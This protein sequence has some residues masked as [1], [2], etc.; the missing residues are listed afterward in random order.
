MGWGFGGYL[1]LIG[2]QHN[3]DLFRCA[4]GINAVTYLN[5]Q[6]GVHPI[7]E[8]IGDAVADPSFEKLT[9]APSTAPVLLVYGSHDTEVHPHQVR[10][11][12]VALGI[13]RNAFERFEIKSGTHE[14]S[15]PEAR[16]RMLEKVEEFL[17]THL[18]QTE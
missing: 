13:Q 5:E 2:S 9:R 11:K 1:A 4:V 18:A 15:D 8:M 10:H 14:L 3:P 17:K 16:A 6:P 7:K 12:S